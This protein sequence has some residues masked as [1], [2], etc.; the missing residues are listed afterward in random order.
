MSDNDNIQCEYYEPKDV[1]STVRIRDSIKC[2]NSFMHLNCRSL[3][4]NWEKFYDF[5]C[6]VHTNTFSFNYIGISEVFR[7]DQDQRISIPGYHNIITRCRDINDDCRGGVALFIKDNIAF[8]IRDDLSV[9]IPHVFES[10]FVEVMP[11]HGKSSIVGIIYRP[12]TAP[13]ADIDIFIT[14]LFGLMDQINNEYKKVVIMGDMNIDML[15]YGTH[16]ATDSYIDGIF[17]RGFLPHVLKP[18][19]VT[20]S[21]ATLIDHFLSNDFNTKSTSGIILNDV[22]DHFAIF[23]STFSNNAP[24]KFADVKQVCVFNEININKFKA[25]LDVIISHQS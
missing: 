8:K 3:S 1:E 21:S 18:T 23:H 13:R 2:S 14:T 10:L 5:L 9:F 16:D 22:A 4:S 25:K 12:N 24:V 7:C 6:D 11:L 15:K 17:S 19:R 20:H